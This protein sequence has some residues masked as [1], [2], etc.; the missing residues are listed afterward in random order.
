MLPGPTIIR[1]CSACTK[2]IEQFTLNSG[3]TIGARFWTDGKRDAPMLPDELWLVKCQQS[4]ALVW[5][6][7]QEQVGIVELEAP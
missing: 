2:L 4:G 7:E 5:I 1:R 3:N 6:D